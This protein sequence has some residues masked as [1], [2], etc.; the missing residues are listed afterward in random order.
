M[1]QL[2]EDERVLWSGR[3]L[4]MPFL[5]GVYII[6]ALG[7]LIFIRLIYVALEYQFWGAFF[8]QR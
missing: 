8:L 7:I 6:V 4:K 1:V 5:F 2:N 3:P